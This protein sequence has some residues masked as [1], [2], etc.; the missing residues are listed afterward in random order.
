MQF[1]SPYQGRTVI[2]L[3]GSSV[4]FTWTFSGGSDGIAG[5][6]WGLKKDDASNFITNGILVSINN[7]GSFMPL[8]SIPLDY[9]GRVTGRL[10]GNKF[11]GQAVFTLNS[12]RRSD[13]RF[14]LCRIFPIS[15]F[16]VS[17]SDH[18]YFVVQGS[19]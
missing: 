14:Y 1:T 12:I 16:E 17:K 18:V 6:S 4:N 10:L 11:S 19:P 15:D 2:G 5:V 3:I 9:R 13:E 7:T 8:P